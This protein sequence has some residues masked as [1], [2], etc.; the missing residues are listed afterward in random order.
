MHFNGVC[1]YVGKFDPPTKFH[2]NTAR[3]L[4][5]RNNISSVIIVLGKEIS[6]L[7]KFQRDKL[8]DIYIKSDFTN[9][10]RT[11][12]TYLGGLEYVREQVIKN[13][14]MQ[15]YIALDENLAQ[16][17]QINE[18]FGQFPNYL[19]EIIPSQ[20]QEESDNMIRSVLDDNLDAFN[21]LIPNTLSEERKRECWDLMKSTEDYV[22]EVL[23]KQWWLSFIKKI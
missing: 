8:W 12:N 7:D 21:D 2:Y 16:S 13:P 10:I 22:S 15:F 6:N 1:F 23:D 14:N 17:D 3:Y 18:I 19:P 11:E 5:S 20:Y 9:K 4:E